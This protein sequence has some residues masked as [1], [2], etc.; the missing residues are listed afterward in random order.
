MNTRLLRQFAPKGTHCRAYTTLSE[1]L[2]NDL[3]TRKLPMSFD[4]LQPQPSHLLNLTLHDVLPQLVKEKNIKSSL[5]SVKKPIPLPTGYHLIYFPPQVTLS[6]L[7]PDGTD[8]LHTPGKPFNRRLWAGG[9][10]K[11]PKTDTDLLLDGSRAV[12]IESIRNVAVKGRDGEEKVIVTIE[13]RVGKA[14]ED[15]TEDQTYHRIWK[16]EEADPGDSSLVENRDLIFM[17]A[18]S[19]EQI[20]IDKAEFAKPGRIVRGTVTSY[21]AVEFD[22]KSSSRRLLL[23]ISLHSSFGCDISS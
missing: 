5:P 11:F 15:E 9:N 16:E 8:V 18:K 12:C 17:R 22:S 2:R 6:Q 7:L 10:V 13:R 19:A 4:Y 23:L 20:E 21:I 1:R 14:S 3:T